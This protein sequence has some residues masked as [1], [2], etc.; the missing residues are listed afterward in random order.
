MSA[1]ITT[2][3]CRAVEGKTRADTP[4]GFCNHCMVH[5]V[6]LSS[7]LFSTHG[8]ADRRL[9]R[10][11]FL[12]LY[13][14]FNFGKKKGKKKKTFILLKTQS[15]AVEREGKEGVIRVRIHLG[16]ALFILFFCFVPPPSKAGSGGTL[17][18]KKKGSNKT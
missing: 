4:I 12:V 16:K 2:V 17:N 14:S 15:D 18:K 1:S 3:Y 8:P 5:E 6:H 10:G 9:E 11:G 13:L 7:F